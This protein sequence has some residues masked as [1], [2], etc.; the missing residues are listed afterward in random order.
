MDGQRLAFGL[1]PGPGGCRRR[2]QLPDLDGDGRQIG[3]DLLFQQAAL[4]GTEALRLGGELHAL[5][6]R[7]LVGEL[8]VQGLA[9][10]QLGQQPRGHLAQL[11]CAQI[12]KGLRRHQHHS[13]CAQDGTALSRA[14]A[15]I[16]RQR[17]TTAMMPASPMRCHGKPSTRASSC[18][19]SSGHC[20]LPGWPDELA[21]VQAPGGQPDAD[22]VVHQH[23]DAVGTLVGEQI[24]VMRTG[25]AEHGDDSGQRRVCAGAHVQRYRGKPGSLDAYGRRIPLLV[26]LAVFALSCLGAAQ[27]DHIGSLLASR[28]V[29]GLAAALTLVVVLS[30]VRNVAKGACAA[31]LRDDSVEGNVRLADQL[32]IGRPL[33]TDHLS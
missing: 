13:Q 18:A 7:V 29:Q 16:A 4:L 21:L 3:F 9:M 25:R 24:G 12:I 1:L 2:L 23:L 30:S 15:T 5:Q 27:S 32:R 31:Q 33:S 6:E 8:G 17:Q 26:G 11:L 22:A 14:D 10:A 19:R 20:S 28:F